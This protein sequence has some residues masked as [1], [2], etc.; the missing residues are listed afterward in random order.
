MLSNN[1]MSSVC[2]FIMVGIMCFALQR[3]KDFLN[4]ANFSLGKILGKEKLTPRMALHPH[5]TRHGRGGI[6]GGLVQHDANM[7]DGT[8]E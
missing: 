6:F 8:R 2:V 3:Y 7:T 1:T 5:W 4:C